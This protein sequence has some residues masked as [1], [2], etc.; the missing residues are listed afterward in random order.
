MRFTAIMLLFCMSTMS[1]SNPCSDSTYVALSQK[2][3]NDMTGNEAAYY[4]QMKSQCEAQ[5]AQELKNQQEIEQANIDDARRELQAQEIKTKAGTA[6]V[7][8]VLGLLIIGVLSF[9]IIKTVT[10]NRIDRATQKLGY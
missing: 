5:K 4:A 9:F 3:L 2:S 6:V 7:S 1:L 10:K 8:G